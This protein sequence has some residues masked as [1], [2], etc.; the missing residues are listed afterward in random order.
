[1]RTIRFLLL[2]LLSLTVTCTW[3]DIIPIP[4]AGTLWAPKSDRRRYRRRK[5]CW[6]TRWPGKV[7]GPRLRESA[8]YPLGS[9]GHTGGGQRADTH[10]ENGSRRGTGEKIPRLVALVKGEFDLV[11]SA[12]PQGKDLE[13]FFPLAYE[14]EGPPETLRFAVAIDGKPAADVKKDN[15]PVTD[16]NQRPR[17]LSGYGW[18]LTGLKGGEKRR[19]VVAVCHGPAT[20]GR[21]GAVHLLPALG[22]PLGWTHRQGGSQRCGRSGGCAWKCSARRRSSRNR[23]PILRSPGKSRTPNRPKTC[24]LSLCPAAQP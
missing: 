5:T 7:L 6:E 2:L 1:M 22:R 15:V 13:V 9:R 18:R 24:G 3:A 23:G 21:Q 12:V 10:K 16:E 20:E 19:I 11:C 17:T 8:G 14:D 4:G